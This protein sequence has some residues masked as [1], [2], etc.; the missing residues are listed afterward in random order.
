MGLVGVWADGCETRWLVFG[1]SISVIGGFAKWDVP[2][3][4]WLPLCEM[5]RI[6]IFP[7]LFLFFYFY[8]STTN[9]GGF[10]FRGVGFMS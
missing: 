8:G 5:A 7:N 9:H 1:G 6:F 10:S 4:V 3:L 2:D